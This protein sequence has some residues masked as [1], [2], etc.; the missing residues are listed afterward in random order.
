MK[1]PSYI[2]EEEAALAVCYSEIELTGLAEVDFRFTVDR[3][4]TAPD[5]GG[6]LFKS[7]T[8]LLC[9]TIML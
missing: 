3:G 1:Q 5:M 6:D 9:S 4:E 8:N 7:R 2:C